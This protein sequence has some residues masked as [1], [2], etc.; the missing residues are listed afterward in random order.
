MRMVF[1]FI[2]LAGM[3]MFA[4]NGCSAREEHGLPLVWSNG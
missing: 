3:T 1:L 4:L 2:F